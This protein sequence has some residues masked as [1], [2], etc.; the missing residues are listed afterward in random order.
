MLTL[1]T[2]L[3]LWLLAIT[4]DSM[5]SE[6]EAELSALMEKFSGTDKTRTLPP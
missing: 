6:I 3:L 5:H 2:N 1:A 4:N